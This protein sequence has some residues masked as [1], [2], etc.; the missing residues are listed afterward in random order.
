MAPDLPERRAESLPLWSLHCCFPNC[1]SKLH[2]PMDLRCRFRRH[3]PP[4]SPA[5][6]KTTPRLRFYAFP[7][8][9]ICVASPRMIEPRH[10]PLRACKRN[11]NPLLRNF[12]I[13]L[14]SL[15][16]TKDLRSAWLPTEAH[17]QKK[18]PARLPLAAG[19]RKPQL[20]ISRQLAR[21]NL[22]APEGTTPQRQQQ[23]VNIVFR[24]SIAIPMPPFRVS[25][26]PCYATTTP[27]ISAPK[28]PHVCR[29]S[30]R[31]R[32]ASG[33]TG[34]IRALDP[35]SSRQSRSLRPPPPRT[36]VYPA[37]PAP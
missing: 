27:G 11:V 21:M 25:S 29:S 26:F 22:P 30:T 33:G 2:H 17:A 14:D 15:R 19:Y 5:R 12:D 3:K 4:E 28:S 24:F 8:L 20:E 34:S 35:T 31:R 9:L 1:C 37:F 6:S 10:E 36:V 7:F 13:G 32:R 23:P 18:P 16:F